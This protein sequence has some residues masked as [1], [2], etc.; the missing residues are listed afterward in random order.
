MEQKYKNEQRR[1]P[2]MDCLT[3]GNYTVTFDKQGAFIERRH[4]HIYYRVTADTATNTVDFMKH[5]RNLCWTMMNNQPE[6]MAA[7]K[8]KTTLK[9]A[10]DENL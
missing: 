5:H 9:A 7:Y 2:P 8:L 3:I 6:D 10:G 4:P 1:K